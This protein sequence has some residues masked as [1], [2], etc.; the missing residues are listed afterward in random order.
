[1]YPKRI[2]KIKMIL[3]SWKPGQHYPI[4]ASR[5]TLVLCCSERRGEDNAKIHILMH[6]I[7]VSME[8]CAAAFNP[9]PDYFFFKITG[10]NGKNL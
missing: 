7:E 9:L 10:L 3:L 4:P 5:S 6:R 1:M 8:L 2:H